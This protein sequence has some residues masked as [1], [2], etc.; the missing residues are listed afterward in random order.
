MK[1]I[2][3]NENLQDTASRA[4]IQDAIIVP[5]TPSTRPS[6]E[7]LQYSIDVDYSYNNN[8]YITMFLG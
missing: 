8:T 7:Q 2:F 5:P 1:L 4:K 6:L 3:S